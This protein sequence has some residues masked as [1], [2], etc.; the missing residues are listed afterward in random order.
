MAC[1]LQALK[2]QWFGRLAYQNTVNQKEKLIE[3]LKK[4]GYPAEFG[5]MI[6]DTL[7]SNKAINR[8][9]AYILEFDPK[10]PEDIAD[11]MLAIQSDIEKW[12]NKKVAEYYN[13]KYN[14]LLNNGLDTDD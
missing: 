7:K 11:E 2:F 13:G 5:L 10:K 8:M 1:G 14:E 6:A 9:I 12:K 3:I 4:R